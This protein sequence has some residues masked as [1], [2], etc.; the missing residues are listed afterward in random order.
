MAIHIFG[1]YCLVVRKSERTAAWE[2]GVR[3]HVT[4]VN[5]QIMERTPDHPGMPPFED[6]ALI[7]IPPARVRGM[8]MWRQAS[9]R[10]WAAR[11]CAI[12][13]CRLAVHSRG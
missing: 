10:R 4:S 11:T 3:A 6:D 8:R 9:S 1:S 13:P 7:P 2:E 5:R 12:S